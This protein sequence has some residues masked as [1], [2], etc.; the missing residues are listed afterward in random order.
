[1]ITKTAEEVLAE[2]RSVLPREF[3]GITLVGCVEE[4][5]KRAKVFSAEKSPMSIAEARTLKTASEKRIATVIQAELTHLTEQTGIAPQDIHIS[6]K[7][8]HRNYESG[9][10]EIVRSSVE[11]L[12]IV[13]PV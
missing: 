9:R 7:T 4:L 12:R 5:L 13:M 3:D 2:I 6:L 10:C 8:I 1:M 11:C